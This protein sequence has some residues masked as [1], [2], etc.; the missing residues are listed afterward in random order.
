M[1]NRINLKYSLALFII[2]L[3][4]ALL[5]FINN[6]RTE[7]YSVSIEGALDTSSSIIIAGTSKTR[8]YLSECEE[9]IRYYDKMLSYTNENGEL[10]KLNSLRESE[11]PEEIFEMVTESG[12]FYSDT[13]GKFDITVGELSES[14]NNAL[15]TGI[16]P[17]END[18]KNNLLSVDYSTLE[19]NSE[20]NKI[21]IT[22]ENQKITLGAV[23][24]GYIADKISEYLQDKDI[25]GA[26]VNLGG[27][28]YV[29][30]RKKNGNLWKIGI[31]DPKDSSGLTGT[32]YLTDKFVITSG[33]Y[34]RYAEIDGVRYHHII[35]AKTGY[36]AQNG[37]HSVTIISEN[38]FEAD[39]LSTSCF[40]MG[41]EKGI[42]LAEK[43]GVEAIFT[44]D[45]KIYY[46]KTLEDIFTDRNENYKY[47]SY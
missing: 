39:A 45:D 3:M 41:I 46:S 29:T 19:T 34:E 15:K 24:K 7:E 9:K 38:G 4:A 2:L 5:I 13:D 26:M 31:M 27:N 12:K 30:G 23:A 42:Q 37:L 17:D 8:E 40:L 35:D 47:I 32:L 14:W 6:I 36:P 33:D 25:E 28:I 43:Y 16:I 11:V 18:I 21:K 20:N 10:Y 1:I 22:K 44:T